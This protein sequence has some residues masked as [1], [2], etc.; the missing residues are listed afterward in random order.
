MRRKKDKK[1]VSM[2]LLLIEFNKGDYQV[3]WIQKNTIY[4]VIRNF[5]KTENPSEIF[6]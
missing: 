6:V 4:E 3:V 5:P 1:V 2:N